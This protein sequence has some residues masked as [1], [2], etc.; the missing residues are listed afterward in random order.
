MRRRH[1]WTKRRKRSRLFFERKFSRNLSLPYLSL[2]SRSYYSELVLLIFACWGL[3]HF[4]I[5]TVLWM[6]GYSMKMR[7]HN[8]WRKQ[9]ARED[10]AMN[11]GEAK[12]GNGTPTRIRSDGFELGSLSSLYS[13]GGRLRDGARRVMGRG[14]VTSQ[15]VQL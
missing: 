6:V 5:W 3:A 10:A 12:P 8:L 4:K 11:S 1:Q 7:E 2:V 13:F 9:K 15:E 14:N